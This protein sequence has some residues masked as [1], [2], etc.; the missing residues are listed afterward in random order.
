VLAVCTG[1]AQEVTIGDR[2]VLTAI[3]KR[4]VDGTAAVRPQGLEGDEQADP[5]VHGGPSKAVYAYP[6]GHHAFWRTVRAQ[7]GAA[8]WDAPVPAGLFGENLLIEGL[9]EERLWIGDRLRLPACTLAVSAPRFPCAKFNAV[10]GFAQAARLMTQSGYCGAYLAVIEP[11]EVRAGDAFELLPGPRE[12][13]LREL[14][15]ATARG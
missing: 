6:S 1:R 9:T 5:S 14:F 8:A 2:R 7:A 4:P 15:K 12:V 13:N 11:G 3:G 10:M